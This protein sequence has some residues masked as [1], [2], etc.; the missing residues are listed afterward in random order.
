MLEDVRVWVGC[1]RA[2]RWHPM[3]SSHSLS[4]SKHM[5]VEDDDQ[6]VIG[7]PVHPQMERANDTHAWA[8][9]GRMHLSHERCVRL[10]R[11]CLA[12]DA[13]I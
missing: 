7:M 6:S 2:M 5:D 10:A 9:L 4:I 1:L 12:L 11:A 8:L 3:R 13:R